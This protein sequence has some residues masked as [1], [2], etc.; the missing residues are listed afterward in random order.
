MFSLSIPRGL[1]SYLIGLP[2]TVY[3]GGFLSFAGSSSAAMI[4]LA[5]VP[6]PTS[7]CLLSERKH[8]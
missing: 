7:L 3:K 4:F 5:H 1:W 8:W 2:L 6:S